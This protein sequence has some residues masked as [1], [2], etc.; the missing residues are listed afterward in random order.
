M[1]CQKEI[2]KQII[3]KKADYILA[4]KGNHSGMQAELEAWWHKVNREGLTDANYQTHTNIDSGHGQIETRKHEQMLL[5]I[6]WL[7]KDYRWAGYDV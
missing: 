7:G 6:K 3:Q 1:G 2:A 5:D 4:L